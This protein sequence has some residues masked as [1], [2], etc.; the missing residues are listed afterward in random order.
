MNKTELLKN[1]ERR[2]ALEHI[3]ELMETHFDEA[4]ETILDGRFSMTFKVTF[5]RTVKSR[6]TAVKVKSSFSKS[7]TDETEELTQDLDQMT[8][9]LEQ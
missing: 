3:K 1:E 4:E 6:Q 9:N 5:D 2:L 8:L 7:Y